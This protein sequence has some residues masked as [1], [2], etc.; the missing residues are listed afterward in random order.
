MCFVDQSS[1]HSNQLRGNFNLDFGGAT[2][3]VDCLH[4]V[5]HRRS[6]GNSGQAVIVVVWCQAQIIDRKDFIAGQYAG[7]CTR[8]P[9][10]YE[11]PGPNQSKD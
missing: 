9:L 8:K 5:F 7:I 4:Q 2:I 1:P 11:S 6:N 10:N 3:R